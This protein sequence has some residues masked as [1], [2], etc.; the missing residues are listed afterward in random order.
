MLSDS[1]LGLEE[2]I[3]RT[4]GL[5][6]RLSIASYV[7]LKAQR[8]LF[9]YFDSEDED[10]ADL[11][12]PFFVLEE[13]DLQ[14]QLINEQELIG[15]CAID[16]TY[17][18]AVN[19]PDDHKGSKLHFLDFVGDMIQSIADRQ[20]KPIA[21]QDVTTYIAISSIQQIQKAVRT[22][23]VQRDADRPATDN[24]WCKYRFHIGDLRGAG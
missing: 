12:R 22:P 1:L 10:Q 16:M 15:L 6:A 14:Y 20:N 9:D 7:Q 17:T 24:W 18:E 3:A 2:L 5:L 13:A 23:K 4:P 8:I 19:D 21:G 11:L